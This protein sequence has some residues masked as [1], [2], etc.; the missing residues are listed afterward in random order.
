M[1]YTIWKYGIKVG[2]NV[3]IRMP[4]DAELLPV[5]V[6]KGQVCIW[7]IVNSENE[8]EDRY[9]HIYGTGHDI[10]VDILRSGIFLGTF[11]LHDGDL[12]FHMFEKVKDD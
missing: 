6:Q 2:D 1:G 8:Y 10:P 5:Q 11:Q 4:K 3:C 9:F 7:A 12:V